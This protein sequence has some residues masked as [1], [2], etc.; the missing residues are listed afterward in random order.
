MYK[1]EY[2]LDGVRVS[3]SKHSGSQASA[4][5]IAEQGVRRYRADHARIVDLTTE[6]AEAWPRNHTSVPAKKIAAQAG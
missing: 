1:I 5:K 6:R 4:R 2:V 3:S